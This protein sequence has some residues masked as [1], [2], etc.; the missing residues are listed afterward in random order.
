MRASGVSGENIQ[1][2]LYFSINFTLEVFRHERYTA[3]RICKRY[4]LDY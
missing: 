2:R 1:S 3:S 4:S